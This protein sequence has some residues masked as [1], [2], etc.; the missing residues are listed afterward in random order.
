MADRPTVAV[1]APNLMVT[2]TV[3]Q[4]P[5]GGDEI[6]FHPGGQGFWVARMIR[7]LG[8]VPILVAPIGGES[9]T[10]V[11][12][13]L[14]AAGISL[15]PA[16][17]A[18]E[19]PAYVHDRRDGR[20]AELARSTSHA[21]SRHELDDLYGTA[22]AQAVATRIFVVTGHLGSWSAP[23]RFYRRL[24]AD[25]G[26]A[27]VTTVGDL[28]GAPLAAFLE[29]GPLDFL[30]ISDEDLAE[31]GVPVEDDAAARRT[32][33]RLLAQGARNVVLSRAHRPCLAYVGE[34]WMTATTPTLQEL[35]HRGAGDSMTAAL[36]VALVRQLSPV[37]TLRLATA[38]GAANVTRHGLASSDVNLV[39][40]LADLVEI[41]EL[42]WMAAPP[43]P[44]P[45]SPET[46][47]A[48][49]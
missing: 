6:H 30:K 34:R 36:A 29:G 40:H 10:V 19:T 45:G 1:F 16:G 44:E 8:E 48:G 43:A 24:A 38:A 9:G 14:A 23:A 12:P 35:D 28:H 18:S 42:P 32:I 33:E 22:L 5:R 17:M 47:P 26:S 41:E 46:L 2:V 7:Q 13:L 11:R 49:V 21:L 27:G 15:A 37:E 25:L 39:A 4:S 31:D 20:R 3:E